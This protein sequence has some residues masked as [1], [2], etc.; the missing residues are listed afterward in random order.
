[1]K[2]LTLLTLGFGLLFPGGLSA[3]PV[4]LGE[5]GAIELE[6]AVAEGQTLWIDPADLPHVTGF[7][8]KPEGACRA[9][10]C[11]PVREGQPGSLVK[12]E[13]DRLLFSPT[14]LADAL[15]QPW[16]AD[17]EAGVWSFAPPSG[18][19]MGGLASNIAPDFEL[20][21]LNGERV[22]LSDL[23]GKKVLLI[24]WASW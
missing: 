4:V 17:E 12:R 22:R 3:G 23:R 9:D 16:L 14:R 8:L 19:E 20:P 6:G 13:G 1:M 2:L 10:I 5:A 15:G 11:I 21:N 18:P 24:T 7:E